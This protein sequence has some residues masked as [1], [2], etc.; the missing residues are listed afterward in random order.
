MSG[1]EFITRKPAPEIKLQVARVILSTSYELNKRPALA[2]AVEEDGE[3]TY[4]FRGVSASD[5]VRK[6]ANA[7]ELDDRSRRRIQHEAEAQLR[8]WMAGYFR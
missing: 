2:I 3:R 5:A 4:W 8:M 1:R 6:I 7:Y